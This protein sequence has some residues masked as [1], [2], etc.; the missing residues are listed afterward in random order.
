MKKIIIGLLV[1]AAGAAA[2]FLYIKNETTGNGDQKQQSLLLGKWGLISTTGANDSLAKKYQYEFMQNGIA[3]IRDSATATADSS[4]Y[5]W[6]KTG[7]LQFKENAADSTADTFVVLK[8]N[9][10][11]LQV[12]NTDSVVYLFS[13]L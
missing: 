4:F 6:N 5:V 8:L 3:L 9:A 11:S 12:R 10:D 2:Y 1:I 13:R 7:E